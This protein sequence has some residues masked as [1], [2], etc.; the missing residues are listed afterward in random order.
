LLALAL[1]ERA[2]TL[3]VPVLEA[4]PFARALWAQTKVDKAIP[5]EF[6][7]AIATILAWAYA[8]KDGK[9]IVVPQVDI[10][11]LGDQGSFNGGLSNA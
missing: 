8:V 1:K 2:R 10:P 6:Y 5:L 9:S 3:N 4:P 7:G 11:A